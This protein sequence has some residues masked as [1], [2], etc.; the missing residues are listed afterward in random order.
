MIVKGEVVP[1]FKYHALKH[2]FLLWAL[3]GSSGVNEHLK[4]R[5]HVAYFKVVEFVL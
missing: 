4:L 3:D 2:A 1:V 5:A